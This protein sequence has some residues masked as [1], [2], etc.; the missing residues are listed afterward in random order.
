MQGEQTDDPVLVW[1]PRLRYT[2]EAF[3]VVLRWAWRHAQRFLVL[4]LRRKK[5]GQATSG[6][7][8]VSAGGDRERTN[9]F[10]AR[11]RQEE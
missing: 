6:I 7:E 8:I 2:G 3:K 9:G 5:W 4:I 1:C 10:P 11:T